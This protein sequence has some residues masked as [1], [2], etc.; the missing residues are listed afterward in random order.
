[1]GIVG[2]GCWFFLTVPAIAFLAV[3]FAYPLFRI[4]LRSLFDPDFTFIH[5][6]TVVA[7]DAYT[8]VIWNTVSLAAM[9]TAI[10]ACLAFPV[11]CVLARARG[12][13]ASALTIGVVL[14]LWTSEL[15]RNFAWTVILGRRGPLNQALLALGAIDQPIS[16]LFATPAVIIGSVHVMLPFMI[17]PMAVVMA[18]IDRRLLAVARGLGASP[19][20]A[21]ANVFWP[22]SLPGVL[23]GIVVVFGLSAGLYVTP[24]VLG[25]QGEAMIAM[26]IDTQGRR[27]LN[28]G[29]ASALSMC[30]VLVTV[31]GAAV[32]L[33]WIGPDLRV[34]GRS[35]D[36]WTSGG[37]EPGGRGTG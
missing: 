26:V 10:T 34:V 6:Q 15:M 19:W 1:M 28:W 33:R 11:A 3:G 16:I 4:V 35:I 5:F 37:S 31:G 32:Y 13:F 2:R 36:L 18:G 23:A 29:L 7:V 8:R 25:S 30:L 9:V 27:S 22:L 24:A 17:L 21:F 12:W 14:P 20:Q